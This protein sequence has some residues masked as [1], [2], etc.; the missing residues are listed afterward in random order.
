M[1]QISQAIQHLFLN[2]REKEK[3]IIYLENEIQKKQTIEKTK[4]QKIKLKNFAKDS[5]NDTKM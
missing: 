4:K 3:R 2:D 5:L 1:S